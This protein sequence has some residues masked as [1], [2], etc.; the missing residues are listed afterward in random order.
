MQ[1]KLFILL[2]FFISQIAFSES[3]TMHFEKCSEGKL[4]RKLFFYKI[5]K[6]VSKNKELLKG[7]DL[8]GSI[9]RTLGA[10]ALSP[11]EIV[12]GYD[13]CLSRLHE[14]FGLSDKKKSLEAYNDWLNCL[15]DSESIKKEVKKLKKC[16]KV[17]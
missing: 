16:F 17:D 5:D 11:A 4:T 10:F 3:L 14:S 6:M 15:P 9:A 13:I 8:D 2:S 1:I 7:D 12:T